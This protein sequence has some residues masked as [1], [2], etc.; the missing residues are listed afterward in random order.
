MDEE[1]DIA[2]MI[3]DCENRSAKLNDWEC[4]FIDSI[5]IQYAKKGSLTPKQSE[6]LNKI[7]EKA[8]E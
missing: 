4:E 8:T 7:W 5:A 1:L 6:Q 3:E 2:Q